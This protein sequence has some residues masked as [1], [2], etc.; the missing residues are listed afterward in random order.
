MRSPNSTTGVLTIDLVELTRNWLRLKSRLDG[1]DCGAVIKAEAYGLG[2]SRAAIQ[3]CQVGC[4]EF[5]VAL[6]D[7]GIY[8]RKVLMEAHLEANIHILSGPIDGGQILEEHGLIP[9]L[10][11]LRDI[12]LWKDEHPLSPADIHVDTGM[13]RLGLSPRDIEILQK[14]PHRIEGLNISYVMSHLACSEDS[15]SAM[16][17]E[18][19]ESFL[20][21]LKLFPGSKASLANSS[22]IFLGEKYHFNLVRPGAAL[23]G[24]NPTPG[25][26]NPMSQVIRL[27]GKILQSIFTKYQ[28]K[29]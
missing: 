29:S 17:S 18:Q 8:L 13:S 20:R 16:N 6:I 7:E 15:K 3:L 23:Y 4:K 9:V 10:N 1:T 25:Q 26:P 28:Q 19:L 12:N 21:A 24:I 27:Q 2:A 5:F 22:G 11:S 14:E